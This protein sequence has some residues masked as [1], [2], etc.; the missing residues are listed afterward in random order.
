MPLVA[1]DRLLAAERNGNIWRVAL[2]LTNSA[3]PVIADSVAL[4]GVGVRNWVSY[5]EV[6]M[7]VVGWQAQFQTN[8]SKAPHDQP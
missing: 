4:P 1:G 5:W 3:N 6:G 7:G 8:F 2:N